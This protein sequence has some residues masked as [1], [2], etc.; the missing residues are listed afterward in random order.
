MLSRGLA[1]PAPPVS[2][3]KGSPAVGS[4]GAAAAADEAAANGGA[5]AAP[6][7]LVP[8]QMPAKGW[9]GGAETAVWVS[10]L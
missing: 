9:G 1:P 10:P 4:Q 3:P 8:L 7:A 2:S 6:T 5:A